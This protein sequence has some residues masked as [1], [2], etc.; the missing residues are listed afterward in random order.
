M[1]GDTQ[2]YRLG[3]NNDQL[4]VNR[5]CAKVWTPTRRDGAHNM[6]NY[7]DARN[8]VRSN[9]S[10]TPDHYNTSY[11]NWTGD[12]VRFKS[13]IEDIDYKQCKQH[14]DSFSTKQ[15]YNFKHNVASSLSTASDEVQKATFGECS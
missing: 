14:W 8:Y 6:W 12:V 10:Q 11:L 13:Q 5:S 1:Y 4:P 7:A 3:V 9:E 2:R 15:K